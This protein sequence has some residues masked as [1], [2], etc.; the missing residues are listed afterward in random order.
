MATLGR[1]QH[2]PFWRVCSSFIIKFSWSKWKLSVSSGFRSDK[3]MGNRSLTRMKHLTHTHTQ[4]HMWNDSDSIRPTKTV[5]LHTTNARMPWHLSSHIFML[6]LGLKIQWRQWPR[7]FREPFKS[8]F[9]QPPGVWIIVLCCHKPVNSPSHVYPLSPLMATVL[10]QYSV[11]KDT[12]HKLVW[13]SHSKVLLD[14]H[15]N[16][17]QWIN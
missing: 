7:S 13:I 16:H 9:L 11:G 3:L 5:K 1:Q 10:K 4:K 17:I 6:Q 15:Y 12:S 14:S 8:S 2:G